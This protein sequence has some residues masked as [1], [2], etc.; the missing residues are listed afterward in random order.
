MKRILRIALLVLALMA[1]VG[2][3]TLAADRF[4]AQAIACDSSTGDG[5]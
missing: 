1:G 4:L 5:C 2:A 3:L